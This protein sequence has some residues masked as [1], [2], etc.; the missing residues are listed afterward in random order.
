MTS[1]YQQQLH[2]FHNGSQILTLSVSQQ[3]D[4]ST[5]S[6]GSS[7]VMEVLWIQTTFNSGRAADSKIG[8]VYGIVDLRFKDQCFDTALEIQHPSLM[9]LLDCSYDCW[10]NMI[11]LHLKHCKK[12]LRKRVQ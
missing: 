10:C 7:L 3:L 6:G 1:C 2:S 9:E 11:T 12:V 5:F 4:G 8:G